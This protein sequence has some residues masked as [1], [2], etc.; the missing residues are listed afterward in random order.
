MLRELI[1][2]SGKIANNPKILNELREAVNSGSR[3]STLEELINSLLMIKVSDTGFSNF[4][5][6]PSRI[7]CINLHDEESLGISMFFMSEGSSFPIHDHPEMLG[8]VYLM[9]GNISYSGYNIL[10]QNLEYTSVEKIQ[11]GTS[12]APLIMPLTSSLGNLHSIK[13]N[14][15]SI[16]F[17][18]FMPNY[19]FP[20]R[21]CTFYKETSQNKLVVD[22]PI[23]DFYEVSYL[24]S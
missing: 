21:L 16:I 18:I 13:A 6:L 5:F 1:A 23:L 9:H 10:Y 15:N 22:D 4:N 8:I 11:N 2:K 12:S 24:Q 17:D 7:G 20:E 3:N 19:A 14:T